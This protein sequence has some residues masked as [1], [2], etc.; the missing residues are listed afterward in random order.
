MRAGQS[1]SLR[2]K[3]NPTGREQ[4]CL[5]MTPLHILACSTVQNIE[6]YRVLIDKYPENLITEDGWGAVPLL[7][8][9]WG[10]AP[11]DIIQYLVES[12]QSLY[13][14]YELNWSEMVKTLG[15][16]NAPSEV[17]Q[18]LLDLQQESFP[19][20]FVDWSSV[21]AVCSESN[22][23]WNQPECFEETFQFLVKCSVTKRINTIGLKQWRDNMAAEIES[24]Q[25]SDLNIDKRVFL[26]TIQSKL[27]EYE[28]EYRKLKEAT[29]ILELALWK[30][31]ID[32][33]IQ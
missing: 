29:T 18:N 26:S 13:P 20:Q 33:H 7:Y 4:D 5:G 32:E 14:D 16:A 30:N 31:K 17:I 23:G 15:M 6:L 11:D 9:I 12:Y 28:T 1:R 2:S 21:L 24:I 10:N 22:R 27:A 19:E 8:A 25:Q 3:L